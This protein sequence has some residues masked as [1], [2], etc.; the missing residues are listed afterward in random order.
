VGGGDIGLAIGVRSIRT[1]RAL[2]VGQAGIKQCGMITRNRVAV[3]GVAQVECVRE[4]ANGSP[5]LYDLY[6]T[7]SK[8]CIG[9]L[10]ER[11]RL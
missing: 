6:S 2:L 8:R 1:A 10:I 9:T 5:M 4:E 3:H 11:R 7:L